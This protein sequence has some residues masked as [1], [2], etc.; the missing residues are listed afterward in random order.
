M[1]IKPLGSAAKHL[2]QRTC[3]ACRKTGVKRELVRLVCGPDGVDVDLT[4]KKSGRG[5]YLCPTLGCWESAVKTGKLETALRTSLKA[6][7]KEKL[8]NYAKG[9]NNT[10]IEARRS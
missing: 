9:F 10:N 6:D 3:I 8:V 4:G 2:P 5:A 1:K 7:N